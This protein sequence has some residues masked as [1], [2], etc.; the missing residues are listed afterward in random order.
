MNSLIKN[1]SN[2]YFHKKWTFGETF[3]YFIK[4]VA[5]RLKIFPNYWERVYY[6]I[7]S[8]NFKKK[9]LV[10]DGKTTYFEFPGGAKLPDI[11]GNKNMFGYICTYLF[12]EIFLFPAY[13]EDKYEKSVVESMDKYMND[14]PYG[15][16]DG[17]FDVTIQQ[18][19]VVIDAGAWIGDFSAY[20]A[21]KGAMVYAFEPTEK[22]FT[23]LCETSKLND[24]CIIPIQKGISNVEKEAFLSTE[25]TGVGNFIS[26]ERDAAS[27]IINLISIDKFVEEN[28]LERVDFIKSDIEG[29]ERDLLRGATK[30][31]KTFAPKLAICTYHLPD[32]PEL[33][34]KIIK[35]ANPDYSVVHI[36]RKLFAAVVK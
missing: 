2:G 18:G 20:A 35:D 14:G 7:V 10:N 4:G 25:E 6:K 23:I 8:N 34:E 5:R 36:Q 28:K 33:L 11:S 26:A 16:T 1:T 24:N 17:K 3:A 29:S 9:W 22:I 21:A 15:Y 27:E 32:D 31:L 19:D 30:V 12:E 13:F